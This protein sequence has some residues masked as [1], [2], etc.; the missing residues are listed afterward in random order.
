[1]VKELGVAYYGNL[2]PDR[3]REDLK[4]ILD[5]G[6]NSIVFAISEYNF[7]IWKDNLYK[8]CEIAKSLDMKVYINLWAWGG[9]FGGEAPS[10]FLHNND[11]HRQ[12]LSKAGKKAPAACFNS[13]VFRKYVRKGIRVFAKKEFIDGFFWD[14]PHF[15]FSSGKSEEFYCRCDYCQNLFKKKANKTMPLEKNE[16]IEKFKEESIIDFIKEISLAVKNIDS[17]KKNIVCLIP[18][19]LETGIKDWD[20]FCS[21]VKDVIDVFSSDP[22]WLLYKESLEY[23]EKYTKKTVDL[24]RKYDLESQ[25]WC[26]AFLVP[27][28]K[29]TELKKAIEIFDKY[30]VDS[31][32]SWCYRGAE[33]MSISSRDPQKVWQVIGEAYNNLKAKYR[34]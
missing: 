3:A 34:L 19:P 14:E 22:Y 25:L 13:P 18:P 24:A 8:I 28:R 16:E 29:E 23:V 12:V 1:M 6:C 15:Y 2:F 30:N 26:L 21:S 10:F 7:K 32:F 4:E 17:T 31:I 27:R 9:V 5:H 20:H 33:G 11:N